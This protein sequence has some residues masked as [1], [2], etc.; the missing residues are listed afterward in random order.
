MLGRVIRDLFRKP[1]REPLSPP[2]APS[3]AE[4]PVYRPGVF[5]VQDLEQAKSIILT[6]EGGLTTDE[7]W[8][9]ETSYLC[10]AIG[11]ELGLDENAL[12]LDYG[13]G[14]GRI[15][16]ALIERYGCAVMGVDISNSMRQL[17][18]G[19]AAHES[20]SAVS[21][22]VLKQLVAR[23]LR[24]D[25]CIAIWVLQHCPVVTM[26]IALIKSALKTDGSLFVLNNIYSAVPTD[27]GWVNDGV[28]I[29]ALLEQEFTALNYSR[30]PKNAT[31][32]FVAEHSF[33]ATLRNNK[34]ALV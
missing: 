17:A 28:N 18:P 6:P 13:C 20:F 29:R 27:K 23:G 32:S 16:K 19:Y 21:P 25:C 15:S 14:I 10:E 9:T 33:M 34:P 2:P 11:Q 26:D 30:L 7:R 31:A 3:T 5:S 12:V 8:E 1:V 4:A 22:I 24:V